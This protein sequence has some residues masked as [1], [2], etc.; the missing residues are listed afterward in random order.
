MQSYIKLYELIVADIMWDF[1]SSASKLP[2]QV[3][4]ISH[5]VILHVQ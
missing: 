1:G 3:W 2:S 4:E 5:H